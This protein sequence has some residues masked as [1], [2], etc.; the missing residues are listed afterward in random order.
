M[1]KYID[2]TAPLRGE[3]LTGRKFGRLICLRRD[4][5]QNWVCLCDCGQEKIVAKR[6]M[7]RGQTSSCG[8]LRRERGR[9]MLTKHGLHK[10]PL[11]GVWHGMK[12]R[13]SRKTHVFYS[14][15]GGR[16]IRVQEPWLSS[17]EAFYADMLPL[18]EHG[19]QIDRI[20]YDGNYCKENCCWSTVKEQCNNR[21]NSVI[22]S[23]NGE[24]RTLPLWAKKLGISPITLR[25]R[26]MSG[27]SVEKALTEKIRKRNA[28]TTKSSNPDLGVL[29]FGDE[30]ASI[31]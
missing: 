23:M 30:T 10:H 16:G 4:G 21:R 24:S 28:V 13:C 2:T 20:D 25:G 14:N 9:S 19:L 17:F 18:W 11:Y 15:Y 31:Q 26:L 12:D 27:W 22:L 1:P 8:C 7:V 3:D 6:F 5:L 29:D